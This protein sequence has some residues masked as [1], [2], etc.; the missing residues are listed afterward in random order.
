[1][2]ASAQNPR[3]GSQDEPDDVIFNNLYG[4]RSIV[5]N[6]PKKLNSL[7][8]SMVRKITPRLK[9]RIYGH[10]FCPVPDLLSGS[11]LTAVIELGM[12]KVRPRYYC[13]AL[14][15]RGKGAL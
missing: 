7:N 15:H 5:L 13:R 4:L 8:G 2:V 9:V 14:Q 6:R 11:G 3:K 10:H 1:M 12:G